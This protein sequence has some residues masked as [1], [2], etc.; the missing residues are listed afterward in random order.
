MR[1]LNAVGKIRQRLQAGSI[2]KLFGG[3][4]TIYCTAH[5]TGA[6]LTKISNGRPSLA[7][8]ESRSVLKS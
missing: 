8:M 1:K 4:Q 6:F 5:G 7:D 2:Q 3:S